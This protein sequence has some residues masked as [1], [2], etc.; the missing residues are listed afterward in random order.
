[1]GMALKCFLGMSNNILS[2]SEPVC[3]KG[4]KK[5][6]FFVNFSCFFITGI[7]EEPNLIQRIL[8][9][10][11][12][13]IVSMVDYRELLM[14]NSSW[15]KIAMFVFILL[16]TLYLCDKSDTDWSNYASYN[17]SLL[18]QNCTFYIFDHC[19]SITIDKCNNCKIFAV[20]IQGRY[21]AYLPACT[22]F[23][24]ICDIC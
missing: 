6:V 2:L 19:A 11:I 9:W 15:F 21:V 16:L 17:L 7:R 18:F 1:M 20:P 22:T 8:N 10:K 23:T 5:G 4:Y 13:R 14:I 12:W 3:P 24:F